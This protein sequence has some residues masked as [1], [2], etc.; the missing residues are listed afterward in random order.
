MLIVKRLFVQPKLEIARKTT[1]LKL[2]LFGEREISVV[3]HVVKDA[4]FELLCLANSE[5]VRLRRGDRVRFRKPVALYRSCGGEVVLSIVR[6]NDLIEVSS[7]RELC[8]RKALSDGFCAVHRHS[9]YRS[10][11]RMVFGITNTAPSGVPLAQVPHMVYAM[12]VGG[13][14]LKV[15]IANGL[16]NVGRLYEQ[17]FL[18]SSILAFVSD[19]NAARRLEVALSNAKHGVYERLT[20]KERLEHIT[21]FRD[22]DASLRIF[23]SRLYTHVL[24]K[25]KRFV[26]IKD[27]KPLPV[28]AFSEEM[29]SR[30]ESSTR[31]CSEKDLD[32]LEGCFEITSYAPGG[33]V[34]EECSGR[35]RVYVPYQLLRNL[36]MNAA[37]VG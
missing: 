30:I 12:Y 9:E 24:P 36:A 8:S 2:G 35:Q 32:N 18:L 7:I 27:S 10:Y 20:V 3:L 11:L 13:S 16:K 17:L 4:D 25:L 28:I 21:S 1:L 31:I 15:G 6:R 34:L 26:S 14:A 5:I 29:L 33:I 22:I 19:A 37:L 23:V